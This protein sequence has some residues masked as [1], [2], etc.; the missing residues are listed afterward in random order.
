MYEWDGEGV[1]EIAVSAEP[2]GDVVH[3]AGVWGSGLA[4]CLP[5]NASFPRFDTNVHVG[6][7]DIFVVSLDP[8]CPVD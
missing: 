2:D 6:R 3:P 5:C 7:W 4:P 8:A 1:S